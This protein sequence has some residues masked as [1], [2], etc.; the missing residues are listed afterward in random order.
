MNQKAVLYVKQFFPV[1]ANVYSNLP[2][3]ASIGVTGTQECFN[4][5]NNSHDCQDPA[6]FIQTLNSILFA[7]HDQFVPHGIDAIPNILDIDIGSPMIYPGENLGERTT[8]KITFMNHRT[9]DCLI[10]PYYANRS[11]D[12][13]YQG[14]FWG[15]FKARNP[16]LKGWPVKIYRGFDNQ[17]LAEM[18]VINLFVDQISGPDSNGEVTITYVDALRF[19]DGDKAL[20]PANSSGSL[21]SAIDSDDLAL[22]LSPAG[23]GNAEYPD[24]STGTHYGAMGEEIV[25][26]TRS[27]DNITIT[28]RGLFNTE[29]TDHDEDEVFQV[30]LYLENMRVDEIIYLLIDQF[31][32]LDAATRI[33]ISE[34][35]DEITNYHNVN[36]TGLI[37]KPESVR[38]LIDEL[39]VQAGLV[40]NDDVVA[41]KI[42]LRTLRPIPPAAP[43]IDSDIIIDGSGIRVKDQFQ[44]LVTAVI[45]FYNQY[46]PFLDVD[47]ERNYYS[48]RG[49]LSDINYEQ[50]SIRLIHSRWVP[51]GGGGVVDSLNTMIIGRYQLPP[52][53]FYFSL[54]RSFSVYEGMGINISPPTAEDATGAQETVPA[55]VVST[56]KL[57]H[58]TAVVAEEMRVTGVNFLQR[59]VIIEFNSFNINLKD[60]HDALYGEAGSGDTVTFILETGVITGSTTVDQFAV[61]NEGWASGVDVT[62]I[63]RGRFQ[64]KGG[65]GGR[66]VYVP[67]QNGGGALYCRSPLTIHCDSGDE[68]E[69]WGGGGG[70]AATDFYVDPNNI[71][72]QALGAGGGG[73]GTLPGAGGDG[74]ALGFSQTTIPAEDGT[75]TTGGGINDLGDF[76]EEIND[77][78]TATAGNGGGPGENGGNSSDG[79]TGG[80]AGAAIDGI[81]YITFS[82]ATPDIRGPQIN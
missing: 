5:R 41:E 2:C 30:V 40:I 25:S 19:L 71:W 32:N 76:A 52:R 75:A 6:N 1:C 59:L 56:K 82:G 64:G 23:I 74:Y 69:I 48:K 63:L 8:A 13:F 28:A 57:W 68:A 55:M 9:S 60:L 21:T 42:K 77:F 61:V 67:A 10:D 70:G 26:Y 20:A 65:N 51:V 17:T 39:I 37:P 18:E 81:S 35:A 80:T 12:P 62:L 44:K 47:E 43:L 45:T 73:A 3:A 33:N 24:T 7:M 22:V 34:W 78:F 15:K 72:Q 49:K 58:E 36:Y 66:A 38:Q 79:N 11:Y 53:L 50:S 16:F 46:N 14:T 29:A 54:P 31:T 4:T 27:G